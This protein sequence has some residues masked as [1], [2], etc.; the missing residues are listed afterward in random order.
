MEASQPVE[1]IWHCQ[2]YIVDELARSLKR[3]MAESSSK[4]DIEDNEDNV[5]KIQ[6]A[7]N[8]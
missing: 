8:K 2:Q 4:I 7:I 6:E 1:R 3:D 5:A